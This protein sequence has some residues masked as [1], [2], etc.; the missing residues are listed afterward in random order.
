MRCL[1]LLTVAGA[2]QVSHLLPVY[3]RMAAVADR[4]AVLSIVTGTFSRR[5]SYSDVAVGSSSAV[6]WIVCLKHA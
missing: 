4:G 1:Y 5:E 6:I 2:V 3:P